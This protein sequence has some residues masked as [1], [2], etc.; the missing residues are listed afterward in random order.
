M[1]I[2]P[3]FQNSGRII[4]NEQIEQNKRKQQFLNMNGIKTKVDGNWSPQQQEQYQKLTTKD[5]HYNTTPLGFLSYL[6]DKTLGD[7]TTYQED[8]AFVSG[9]SGEI[10]QD[11][12]SSAR[13]YLDQQM[14]NNQTPL[15]YITQTVLPSAAIAGALVYGGPTIVNGVRTAVSNPSSILPAAK[16]LVK[17]GVKGIAGATAVNAASK[18]TTGKTWGEQVA[19]STGVSPDFGEFTNPG[20]ILGSPVYNASKSEIKYLFP[21]AR[22]YSDN[23]A[24]NAYATLARRYNL[25]DKARLP[26]LIR[27]IKSNTLDITDDGNVILNGYRFNHTN[28]TYDRPVVSHSKGKWDN[29]QQTLLINPRNIVRENKFGSIEPSDM[30]TVQ[31]P[32]GGLLASPKDVINITANPTAIRQSTRHQIQTFN[33]TS[34]REQELKQ[35]LSEQ[36]AY[37][38]NFGKRLKFAKDGRSSANRNYWEAVHNIQKK[39]GKPKTKD[40]RL[41]EQVTRLKSGISDIKDLSKFRALKYEDIMNTPLSEID[42]IRNSLP[43]FGNNREFY[44]GLGSEDYRGITYPY[45]NFFYDPATPAESKFI[46][47][48]Q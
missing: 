37:L 6:Y 9:Y 12:R 17:E 43:R 7:G 4:T 35:L 44:L 10:K 26:Y 34:L 30:F 11:D 14:Q 36:Q 22:L 2:V 19:Q 15:G 38:A 18:A 25:P 3:K 28:F 31:D 41:L 29:A 39:F 42:N 21:K 40:V 27:R 48:N 5:K 46:F 8:P 33:S 13:R 32:A 47:P 45:K 1:K 16:T 20:F 23:P 24:V